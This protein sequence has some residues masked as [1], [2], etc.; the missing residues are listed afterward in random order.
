[1]LLLIFSITLGIEGSIGYALAV[2][3]LSLVQIGLF[4]VVLFGAVFFI[5]AIIIVF[6][7]K[8]RH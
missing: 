5:P 6:I 4:F 8:R 3:M 2:T 1:M 7:A